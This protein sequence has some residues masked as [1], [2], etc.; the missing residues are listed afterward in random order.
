MSIVAT[1]R[2]G[3]RRHGLRSIVPL[4]SYYARRIAGELTGP[5]RECPVCGATPREFVPFVELR[6]G[7]VRPRAVCA[8]CGALERHRAYA[9]FYQQFVTRNFTGPVDVLHASAED[10]LAPTFAR[11]ARRYD[12][13]DYESPPPGHIQLDI[14]DPHLPR[15]SYDLIVLNHVLMCV[16]D[17]RLAVRQLGKLLRPG[18]AILAGEAIR[19]GQPTASQPKPGYGGRFNYYGDVDVADRFAPMH[20]SVINVAEQL[21]PEQRKRYGIVDDEPILV[22]RPATDG[23]ARGT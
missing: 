20:A 17:D 5:G 13:S 8:S 6:Y 16:P 15:A 2:E 19:R 23:A 7:M 1:F 18:G 21:G 12:P 9:L 11:L 3:I 14:C 22:I 10:A 4:S